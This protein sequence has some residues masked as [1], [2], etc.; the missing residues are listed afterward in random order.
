[1]KKENNKIT[2]I[3]WNKIYEIK[4]N[5]INKVKLAKKKNQK[6]QII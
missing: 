3:K 6:C 1:M 4:Q 5:M 2:K